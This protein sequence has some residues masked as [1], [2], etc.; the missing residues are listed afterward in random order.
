L[1]L[2]QDKCQLGQLT[3]III[4]VLLFIISTPF[5]IILLNNVIN[6]CHISKQDKAC[7]AH[8]QLQLT[9]L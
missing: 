1:D 7:A 9:K 3:E 2:I 4:S 6:Y 8:E 5:F